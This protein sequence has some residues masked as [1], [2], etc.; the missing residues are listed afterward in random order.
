MIDHVVSNVGVACLAWQV[1]RWAAA[2]SA[3]ANPARRLIV[4]GA[5]LEVAG[6][7]AD[8]VGHVAGGEQPA[9]FAALGLGYLLVVAGAVM[10]SRSGPA[11]A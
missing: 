10:A 2:G 3:W 6:A 8:G 5:G 11:D 9:A 7:V 1:G 4:V